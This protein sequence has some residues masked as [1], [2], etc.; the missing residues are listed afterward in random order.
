MEVHTFISFRASEYNVF[1]QVDCKVLIA[2]RR[3]IFK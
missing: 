1:T 2:L 3:E